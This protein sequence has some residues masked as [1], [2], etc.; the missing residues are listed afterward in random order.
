M[1][2]NVV[3]QGKASGINPLYGR[4]IPIMIISALSIVGLFFVAYLYF[5]LALPMF[6]SESASPVA[7][8]L[9]SL[10]ILALLNLFGFWRVKK[11]NVCWNVLGANKIVLWSYQTIFVVVLV[12]C[13]LFVAAV[14]W[15]YLSRYLI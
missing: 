10:A 12:G 15:F 11:L 8:V 4:V 2:I 9:C 5:F 1:N 6:G 3:E 7:M 14:G 13:N